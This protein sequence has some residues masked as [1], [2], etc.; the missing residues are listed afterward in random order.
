MTYS[1]KL[2]TPLSNFEAGK[3]KEVQDPAITVRFRVEDPN[4]LGIDGPLFIL[5]WTTTPWTL[6][7]NLALCA[8]G[9]IGRRERPRVRRSLRARA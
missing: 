7:A 6:P 5:A 8:G 1:F 2:A 9:S 4:R 3:Y